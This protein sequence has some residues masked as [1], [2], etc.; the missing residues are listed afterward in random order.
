MMKMENIRHLS[1]DKKLR[2]VKDEFPEL[3]ISRS[4]YYNI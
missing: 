2:K 1:L 4:T 3:K